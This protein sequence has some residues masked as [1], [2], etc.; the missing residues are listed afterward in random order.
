MGLE[1]G[2]AA[3]IGAGWTGAGIAALLAS[4][5]IETLL[6]DV[7][8]PMEP[9]EE[10]A[11]QGLTRFSE[12]W[13]N[14]LAAQGLERAFKQ[15]AFLDPDARARVK[16]G[17]VQDH[18]PLVADVD[19][20]LEAVP[21]V[22][23]VKRALYD[24][25][26]TYLNPNAFISSN[27]S[28][29]LVEQL[30]KGRTD[31]FA[32]R[33]LV[34]HFFTP[35]RMMRLMEL[36]PGPHT[37]RELVERMSEL[38]VRRLGKGVI[39]VRDTPYF[40]ANRV[41]QFALLTAMH[42]AERMGI[43]VAEADRLT[44]PAMARPRSATFRTADMIGLDALLLVFDNLHGAL[45]GDPWRERFN[46]PAF[47]R[48]MVGR[49]L[50]GDKHGSGFYRP[51][52]SGEPE[53][54]DLMTLAYARQP[55][56]RFASLE[57]ALETA[58]PEE[59]L[60]LLIDG[61]DEGSRFAWAVVRDVLAY[62]AWLLGKVADEPIVFDRALRWGY[63]WDLG[64]F[65]IWDALGAPAI[66]ERMAADGVAVPETVERL[67]TSGEAR[68]YRLDGGRR[69]QYA[70]GGARQDVP[71]PK[72]SL[73]LREIRPLKGTIIEDGRY[74]LIDIDDGVA[75]L[76]IGRSSDLPPK[77]ERRFVAF[78]ARCL[79]KAA[80]LGLKGFII[81]AER[82]D[83]SLGLDLAEIF[84]LIE[85]KNWQGLEADVRQ[86]QE[87]NRL[88]QTS[89]FPIV[90]VPAHHTLGAGCEMVLH[91]SRIHAHVETQFGFNETQAGL[92]P[93]GGGC[94]AILQLAADR[95]KQDGPFPIAKLAMETIFKGRSAKGVYEARAMGFLRRTD[96]FSM[97]FER[98]L[99]DAKQ[100]VLELGGTGFRQPTPALFLPGRG[101][102]TEL[103]LELQHR[104][105]LGEIDAHDFA[106]GREL[107]RVLTGGDAAPHV[108]I[109]DKRLLDLE[110]E[111]FLRLAGMP[112][113]AERIRR[114][115]GG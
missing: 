16:I 24:R 64:P 97:S 12:A 103:T 34:S 80:S 99:G 75:A 7:L 69:R 40:V 90:A 4:T 54:L 15:G 3:V 58:A 18:L 106:V 89:A 104:R 19:W 46:A 32:S 30:T 14:R 6:L 49:G 79:D 38:A 108:P 66:A 74:D 31:A 55:A 88:L 105:R 17:N 87:V 41:G 52:A 8:P 23:D 47:M 91:C 25:L 1:I 56:R 45:A 43:S 36:A 20:V 102:A 101:G 100:T 11:Q 86:R 115:L 37:R 60:R 95:V 114:S 73:R 96:R 48:L 70:S 35:V 57:R 9:S 27:T 84:S 63:N 59:R 5:G 29:L 76:A 2:R 53:T 33:F 51:A 77:M 28:G 92:I 93:S 98:L 21:E 22:L 71:H 107:A 78:I 85:R 65:E 62:S 112:A 83:F 42:H 13:R 110:C 72:G 61:D 50:W 68:W 44:G 81:V 111:S 67:L 109:D 26:A 94:K 10:E 39:V 113:T 82:G